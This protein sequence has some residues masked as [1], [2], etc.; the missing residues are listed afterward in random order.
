MIEITIPEG[1]RFKA[2]G[3]HVVEFR[4]DSE[5]IKEA[6]S[7]LSTDKRKLLAKCPAD[8]EFCEDPW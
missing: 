6:K 2:S 4:N 1:R 7:L 5:G 3:L 8:C